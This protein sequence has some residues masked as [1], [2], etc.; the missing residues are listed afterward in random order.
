VPNA[1]LALLD[2]HRDLGVHTELLSDGVVTGTRKPTHRNKIIATTALGTQRLFEFLAENAGV[3]FWPVDATN[4]PRLI[5]EEDHMVAINATLEV[6]FLGQCTR[7]LIA[8]A[9]PRFHDELERAAR[10]M[11]YLA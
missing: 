4:D 9:H 10:A 1:V 11:G 2:G 6:D 7:R 8:I 5:A 3:E